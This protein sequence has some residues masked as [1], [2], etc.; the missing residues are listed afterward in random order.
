[1]TV[2]KEIGDES[3]CPECNQSSMHKT[4]TETKVVRW[5]SKCDYEFIYKKRK[6]Q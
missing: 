6:T 4:E 2:I 1:M 5:C 3:I